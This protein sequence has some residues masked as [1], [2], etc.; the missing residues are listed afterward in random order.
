MTS[1]YANRVCL[2]LFFMVISLFGLAQRDTVIVKKDPLVIKKEVYYANFFN[3][4]DA[5]NYLKL[6]FYVTPKI[7][8]QTSHLRYNKLA[9]DLEK[10]K[11]QWSVSYTRRLKGLDLGLGIGF[12]TSHYHVTQSPFSKIVTD[13]NQVWQKDTLDSYFVTSSGMTNEVFVVDSSLIWDKTNPAK[14]TTISFSSKVSYLR[15]PFHFGYSF[16]HKRVSIGLGLNIIPNISFSQ[17][18]TVNFLNE[19][20]EEEPFELF[21]GSFV[22]LSPEVNVGY[23]FDRGIGAFLSYR[24]NANL[25]N[26]ADLNELNTFSHSFGAGIK[27]FF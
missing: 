5:K 7:S 25:N 20:H 8:D 2:L 14:D 15:L 24:V 11:K 6:D 9:M 21:N 17:G 3:P 16:N 12:N 26:Y 27:Y 4:R 22:E 1:S 19:E 18:K 10:V 23:N 13:S